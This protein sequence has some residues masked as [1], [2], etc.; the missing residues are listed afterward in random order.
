MNPETIAVLDRIVFACFIGTWI[1]LGI[2]GVFLFYL[3]KN[4]AFKR[5]WFPRYVILVGI[6][7]VSFV[8]AITALSSSSHEVW[9]ML[10]F[11]LPVIMLITYMNVKLTKFC[12]KCGS[13]LFPQNWFAPLRFCPKCGAELGAKSGPTDD[14]AERVP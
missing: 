1:I 11:M 10:A 13:T 3:S 12:D 2:V 7:F 9:R 6:L 4:V 14:L 8:T 5:K